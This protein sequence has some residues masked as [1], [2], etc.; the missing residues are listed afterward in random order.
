MVLPQRSVRQASS[1]Q[2]QPESLVDEARNQLLRSPYPAIRSLTCECCGQ[3]LRLTGHVSSFFEKQLA[4]CAVMT[5]VRGVAAL[6]NQV[7]VGKIDLS[8]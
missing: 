6:D 3:T 4:Q 7:E 2:R 5:V 8:R 1:G